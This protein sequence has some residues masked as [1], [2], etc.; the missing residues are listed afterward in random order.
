MKLIFSFLIILIVFANGISSQWIEQ[1]SGVTT[2]LNAVYSSPNNVN[3]AWICGDNGVVLRTTNGGTNWINV[4]SNLPVIYNF[5][6]IIETGNQ[7]VLIAGR[8]SGSSSLVYR[9]TNGGLNWILVFS[10]DLVQ[11]YGFANQGILLLIGS[12]LN[13]RWQIWRSTNFGTNWDSTGL[14]LFQSGNETGFINSVWSVD[15]MIWV[16]TN[17]SKIYSSPSGGVTW[18]TQ[19]I[20]PETESRVVVFSSILTDA[21]GYGFSGGT[22][23][24]KSSNSGTNWLPVNTPGSGIITAAAI[25]FG[26]TASNWYA[27]GNKIYAGVNGD[28]FNFQYTSPFGNY[29]HMHSNLTSNTVVWAVRDNGGISKYTG[30]IGIQTISNEIPNSFSLSQNYPNPFNPSTKIRF[31]IP[32]LNLPLTG[33]D[34]EGVIL[35]IYNALG[36]EITTLVNQ[37]L[38]PGTYEV[39]WDASNYPSGLYFYRLTS[40]SFTE[41]K[42]MILL[43]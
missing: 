26:T 35:R 4:S 16:G 11:Y 24:L 13:G 28:N 15:N 23:A 14:R 7:N 22:N 20:S 18:N 1:Q 17:N 6:S 9:S 21:I 33:G 3:N 34:R 41:T 25:G 42:K 10:Q 29:K 30:Q 39:D 36:S 19:S 5:T 32:P 8:N 40:G 37:Q 38:S 27:K 43:K 31:A 12:P 2:S